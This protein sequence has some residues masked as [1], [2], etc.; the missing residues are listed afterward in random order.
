MGALLTER[1]AYMASIESMEQVAALGANVPDKTA[2]LLG[3]Y[4]AICPIAVLD[5]IRQTLKGPVLLELLSKNKNRDLIRSSIITSAACGFQGVLLASGIFSSGDGKAKPVYDLDQA[6]MLRLA[7]GLRETE[8]IPNSFI[9]AVRSASGNA[10]AEL[11]ARW[12]IEEGADYI[13]L[14]KGAVPGLESKTLLIEPV[15]PA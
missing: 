12:Y 5:G 4:G 9:I 10:P 3:E 13:A 15:R 6:Q 1:L 7:L 11:R 2:L 14:E 8:A